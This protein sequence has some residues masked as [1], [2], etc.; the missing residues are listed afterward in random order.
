MD[1]YFAFQWHL[2]DSCDQRCKHCYIFSEDCNLPIKDM[3]FRDIK[4]V[5]VNC[6]EMCKNIGRI[7][8]L[9]ITGG[10]P[11]LHDN[12]W[13]FLELVK[14]H[15][16]SFTILGNPFH[17]NETVCKK[18]KE[19]GCD[20]Y[21][22]S[23]DGLEKTHDYFRKPGSFVATLE[24]IKYLK[25]AGIKAV[26]MT[27]VSRINMAEIP[28]IIDIV[29]DHGVNIYAFAR[30]C[31]S[32]PGVKTDITPEEYKMLLEKCWERFENYR[33]AETSFYLKD[34]LWKLFLYEK[35]IFN[36]PEKLETNKIYDGCNCSI[37]H[38][39]ILP[40]G[41]VYAC[42]RFES[43]VG[44]AITDSLYDVFLGSKMEEYRKYSEFEKCSKCELMRFC[45]GCPAV[46]K[47]NNGSFYSAD[48]QCWK[49]VS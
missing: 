4:S 39:T 8:Y 15:D 5:L 10:D 30:Y 33:D 16:I 6:L 20:R 17:L 38:M 28:E 23:I 12:F 44:N 19:H 42:R 24:K 27:T 34:H 47:S 48:P 35:G 36:M 29:V 14:K 40:D 2:T 7:P 22:M 37:S 43:K 9:Y 49:E 25:N 41:D 1:R 18:L 32:S 21:Q 3:N 26:I 46:A 45:R 13:E 31:P 11:I